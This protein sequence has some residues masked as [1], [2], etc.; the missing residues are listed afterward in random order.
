MSQ[1]LKSFETFSSWNVVGL[2]QYE[3]TQE[4]PT[5]DIEIY[6][7]LSRKNVYTIVEI[8]S[9]KSDTFDQHASLLVYLFRVTQKI[10]GTQ[11]GLW[12]SRPFL[13]LAHLLLKMLLLLHQLL[14]SDRFWP[15]L[16]SSRLAS[17]RRMTLQRWLDSMSG[18]S[19]QLCRGLQSPY[20]PLV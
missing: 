20:H 1:T 5:E 16:S 6:Y 8:F 7:Y 18:V 13:K 3:L 19:F 17:T 4:K 9:L 12:I 10:H 14:T 15:L 11:I 2:R